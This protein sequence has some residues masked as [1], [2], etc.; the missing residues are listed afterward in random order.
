MENK[1]M[2]ETIQKYA[3]VTFIWKCLC[4]QKIIL[5]DDDMYLYIMMI[6]I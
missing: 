5:F 3:K 1:N 6:S 4:L 2:R